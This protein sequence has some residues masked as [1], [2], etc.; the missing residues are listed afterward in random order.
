MVTKVD[1]L[2]SLIINSDPVYL[3]S[4]K[5]IVYSSD[6]IIVVVDVH[7][8][9]SQLMRGH[10][11]S[12]VSLVPEI[13]RPHYVVSGGLDGKI[14]VWD[15]KT[16]EMVQTLDTKFPIDFCFPISTGYV[17]SHMYKNKR[18]CLLIIFS[19][20]D[21]VKSY[22][23]SSGTYVDYVDFPGNAI[24][25]YKDPEFVACVVDSIL[26]IY[27]VNL[28][29]SVRYS[30]PTGN[31]YGEKK[32]Y[33]CIAAHPNDCIIATGN[34]IGEIFVWWNLCAQNDDH[35]NLLNPASDE[36]IKDE[37]CAEND[38]FDDVKLA[39]KKAVAEG[40]L[41]TYYPVHPSHVKRSL[42]RWHSVQ[43]TSL[44]FT[45][46]G[47]HLLSGGLK[48][49]LV[50]WD[51]TDCFGGP[52]QR[53]F[54]PHFGSP[55]SS[56]QSHGG[57]CED[58]I[59]VTLEN[60]SFHI[61][62]GAFTII[63][64]KQG[65]M[66][67]PKRWLQIPG[68]EVPKNLM[69]LQ[70]R[71]TNTSHEPTATYFLING[72][73]GKLQ[74]TNVN[75]NERNVQQIDITHQNI[76]IR[77]INSKLPV[78]YAEVL[79]MAQLSTEISFTWLVTYECVKVSPDQ[80][81]IDNQ[82]RLTWW[83]CSKSNEDDQQ[84]VISKTHDYIKF[85]SIDT[86]SMSH[87]GCPA[88]SMEF[89]PSEK[90][91][92]YVLLIDYRLMIWNYN[93]E[94]KK[95][96]IY[97]PWIPVLCHSLSYTNLYQS[98]LPPSSLII[99]FNIQSSVNHYNTASTSLLIYSSVNMTLFNWDKILLEINPKHSASIC[100]KD[101]LLELWPDSNKLNIDKCVI[102]SYTGDNNDDHNTTCYLAMTIRG[103]GSR[104]LNE[105]ILH[106]CVCLVKCTPSSIQIMSIISDVLATCL[107][108][109]P[110]KSYIAVGLQNGTVNIY[111]IQLNETIATLNMMYSLP[112]LSIQ[113]LCDRKHK[114]GIKY[115]HKKTSNGTLITSLCFM[116]S[117]HA[118][119][120]D[121]Q[122]VGLMKTLIGRE[123]G[124]Y[125]LVY[126][127]KRVV[128]HKNTKEP[129]QL[130]NAQPK[131]HGLLRLVD[132]VSPVKFDNNR[133]ICK[134]K[135]DSDIQLE[136]TLKQISDYPI[137]TAPPPDQLLHQLMRKH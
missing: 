42:L 63:Y 7:T 78:M 133:R 44:C 130:S 70:N 27:W 31:K 115:K 57:F 8:G 109:H 77:D 112:N 1:R 71:F 76:I 19:L 74:L 17:F 119:I 38:N 68:S 43:V 16:Y 13:D 64:S 61:L 128:M 72:G 29:V 113:P 40:R 9:I 6:K 114:T 103:H 88:V 45:S 125:D 48:G 82:S 65:F 37:D 73:N 30:V 96:P 85:T 75:D 35:F 14:I 127:G 15:V 107:T 122:L 110:S 32:N 118:L 67:L 4:E 23:R 94:F 131:Q 34:A 126:Y 86:Y 18:N 124:R 81:M 62:D 134:R 20:I 95:N 97:S 120:D 60:N 104:K 59:S 98:I 100:L 51:M 79:L 46:C 116:H 2:S 28:N 87:F 111:Q 22:D 39:I 33:T 108:S 54:L 26:I 101:K 136:N 92:L 135:L 137:Y 12:V 41:L 93:S 56:V 69:I 55:I 5:C 11:D 99:P 89:V 80:Q 53:R 49:V 129:G 10:K 91:E 105:R 25:T 83:Q 3:K 84:E 47:A 106:G 66:Q 50:K 36:W 123:I 132:V 58:T 121:I 90:N 24:I 117:N 102:I 21:F 52:Q